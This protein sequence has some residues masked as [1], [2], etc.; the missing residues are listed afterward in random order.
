MSNILCDAN[1]S[2]GVEV[3]DIGQFRNSWSQ[4]L[5][6]YIW[7]VIDRDCFGSSDPGDMD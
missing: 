5:N 4:L 1:M 7:P 3:G 2:V 6:T